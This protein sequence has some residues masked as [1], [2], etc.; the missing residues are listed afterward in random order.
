MLSKSRELQHTKA[1]DQLKKWTKAIN[2]IA[3]RKRVMSKRTKAIKKLRYYYYGLA[4]G[5][6]CTPR[7][8]DHNYISVA[9]CWGLHLRSRRGSI[10]QQISLAQPKL[11]VLACPL[12]LALSLPAP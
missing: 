5:S 6:C 10:T 12:V 1:L 3:Q 8:C 7:L 11:G 2:I 4:F 9:M